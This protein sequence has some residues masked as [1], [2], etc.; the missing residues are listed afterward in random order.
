MLFLTFA[1]VKQVVEVASL[2]RNLIV[3]DLYSGVGSISLFIA[4]LVKRVVAVE[5]C[6][7]AVQ[8]ALFN[9]KLNEVENVQFLC[10]KA[11]QVLAGAL[12]G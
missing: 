1:V 9:A 7:A 10:G 12:A 5:D 11:E 2:H 3:W 6:E 8:D 4:P